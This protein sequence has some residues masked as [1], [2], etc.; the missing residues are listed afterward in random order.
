VLEPKR[1]IVKMVGRSS[2]GENGTFVH[3]EPGKTGKHYGFS[4]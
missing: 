2:L 3:S 1:K 4:K